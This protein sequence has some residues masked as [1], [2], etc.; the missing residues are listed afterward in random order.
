MPQIKRI[1]FYDLLKFLAIVF[2][3][4]DHIGFYF[5]TENEVFR[6]IGRFAAPLFFFLTGYNSSTKLD[7]RIFIGAIILQIFLIFIEQKFTLNI[8]FTIL[9]LRIFNN[10]LK[11]ISL[12]FY[13]LS[14]LTIISS[15]F[16]IFTNYLFEYGTIAILFALSGKLYKTKHKYFKTYLILSTLIYLS[17][18]YISFNFTITAII[19]WL[20]TIITL[21]YFL[22]T[23]SIKENPAIPKIA[24]Y[25]LQIYLTHYI[26]FS[27]ISKLFL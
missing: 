6:Q 17:T 3:V 10:Y 27:T 5:F 25:S 9:L 15:S 11:T 4:T 23:K 2:M 21:N 13:N 12:N 1:F 16:W 19:T 26:L 14:L 24:K 22:K 7:S 18:Q 20:L 8:L